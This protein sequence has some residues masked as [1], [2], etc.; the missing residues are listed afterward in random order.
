MCDIVMLSSLPFPSV[1]GRAVHQH[2]CVFVCVF[3]CL[4]VFVFQGIIMCTLR[5]ENVL[6]KPISCTY[7]LESMR[8]P[9]NPCTF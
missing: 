5:G 8:S 9:E 7:R 4:C 6:R 2:V 3:L 1:F